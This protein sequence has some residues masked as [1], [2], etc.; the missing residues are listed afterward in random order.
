M[1][2]LDLIGVVARAQPV[3][4][5]VDDAQWLDRSSVQTIG[6]VGR[7]VRAERG[8]IVS[9]APGAT[10]LGSQ[11]RGCRHAVRFGGNW[12][13]RSGRPR[14]DHRGDAWKSARSAGA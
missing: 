12:A 5:V 13:H 1:A 2:V 10:T 14:S 4:W 7:R 11:H 3:M 8:V 9:R 6:F